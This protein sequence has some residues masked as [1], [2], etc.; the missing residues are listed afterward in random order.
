MMKCYYHPDRDA[1]GTCL[2]CGRGLC[3]ECIDKYSAPICSDCNLKRLQND[4]Q[5]VYKEFIITAVLAVIGIVLAFAGEPHGLMDVLT[6]IWGTAGIYP[7]WRA[8]NKITPNI[9]LVL[10]LVGWLFYFIIKFIISVCIG[11]ICLP[12]RLVMNIRKLKWLKD[13]EAYAGQ[14]GH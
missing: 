4:K 1:V 10:P 3:Q 12:I 14:N 9:F 8:L 5:G 11:W 13:V 7:G 6:V 2:D